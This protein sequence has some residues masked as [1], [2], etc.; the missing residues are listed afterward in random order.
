MGVTIM[1]HPLRIELTIVVIK[2]YIV[3]VCNMFIKNL[4]KIISKLMN[5]FTQS[6]CYEQDATQSIFK[7]NTTALW[8]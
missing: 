5:V 3:Y 2:Y 1:E 8:I 7:K 6:F 4:M